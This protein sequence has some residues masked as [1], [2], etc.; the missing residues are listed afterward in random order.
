MLLFSTMMV[1]T[2]DS[3]VLQYFCNYKKLQAAKKELFR[4]P[5]HWQCKNSFVPFLMHQLQFHC[6]P[7]IN[8]F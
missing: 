1:V 4:N 5:L 2:K 6:L 8:S 3:L 7:H